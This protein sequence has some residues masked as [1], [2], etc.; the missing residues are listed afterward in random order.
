MKRRVIVFATVIAFALSGCV[1]SDNQTSSTKSSGLK[2]C[3]MVQDDKSVDSELTVD[4]ANSVVQA[5][6][7]ITKTDKV[8]FTLYKDIK[9]DYKSVVK[10]TV[11]DK[12]NI[13]FGIGDYMTEAMT[14]IANTTPNV[15]FVSIASPF[16][17]EKLTGKNTKSIVFE[18][19][20][21]GF[22]AGYL[23]A[24]MTRSGKVAT[25]GLYASKSMTDYM[26]GY[27]DGVAKYNADNGSAVEVLGWDRRKQ[28]G[29]FVD[30][31]VTSDLKT[32]LKATG[33]YTKITA[34]YDEQIQ[35]KSAQITKEMITK[36]AD[37]LMP[38]LGQYSFSALETIKQ[39]SG[40]NA[41]VTDRTN[42]EV[43]PAY[44]DVTL[45]VL[46]ISV[47]KAM[48]NVL[49]SYKNGKFDTKPYIAS[50]KNGGVSLSYNPQLENNIP[51]SLKDNINKLKEK[52]ISG[53]LNVP[54]PVDKSH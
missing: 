50:L 2:A 47:Q 4:L 39:S 52:I 38:A 31:N 7:E 24:G 53:S 18:T 10:K 35:Q 37:I 12:C 23:S 26:D 20:Q 30:D 28:K 25:F 48:K 40:V 51:Q 13:V 33:E 16:D 21:T 43:L 46:S 15:K 1:S 36:G 9:N 8:N 32:A 41:I 44:S 17:T 19:A 49:N 14:S 27:A 34:K 45:E 5:S 6:K 22:L 54:L 11:S 3:I 29:V 42:V